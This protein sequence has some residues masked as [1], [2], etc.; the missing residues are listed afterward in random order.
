MKKEN[1]PSVCTAKSIGM[2]YVGE[3]LDNEK[4]YSVIYETER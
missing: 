1:I 3:Y 4:E 2:H